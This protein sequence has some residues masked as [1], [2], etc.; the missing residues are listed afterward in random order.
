M[1]LTTE[2]LSEITQLSEK[3]IKLIEVG[4]HQITHQIFDTLR[5]CLELDP[6]ELINIGKI[7]QVQNIMNLYKEIDEHYPR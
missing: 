2:Q 4:R 6:N 5:V 7:T 1:E 3:E